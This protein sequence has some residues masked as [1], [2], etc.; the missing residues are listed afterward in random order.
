[1][2]AVILWSFPTVRPL[3]ESS[4]WAHQSMQTFFSSTTCATNWHVEPHKPA[5]TQN[6]KHQYYL[7]NNFAPIGNLHLQSRIEQ[8]HQ[9]STNLTSNNPAALPTKRLLLAENDRPADCRPALSS[10]S[11]SIDTTPTLK[12]SFH[13]CRYQ[14][15]YYH[16]QRIMS[17]DDAFRGTS[18]LRDH[19][20]IWSTNKPTST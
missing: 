2:Y 12:L 1:M 19:H 14:Q 16:W 6:N 17:Q 7:H 9:Q 13:Y 3:P 20:I 15:R 10:T 18:T 11:I 5:T 4:L 8:S